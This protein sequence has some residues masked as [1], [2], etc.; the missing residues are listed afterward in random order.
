M[1]YIYRR[2]GSNEY[3]Q[4]MFW[5]KTKKKM[6]TPLNPSFAIKMWFNGVTFHG[7]VFLMQFYVAVGGFLVPHPQNNNNSISQPPRC[8]VYRI[9]DEVYVAETAILPIKFV[10]KYLVYSVYSMTFK[11]GFYCLQK[12]I[13]SLNF[14]LLCCCQ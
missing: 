6:F 11:V 1:M 13:I 4:S 8:Q 12:N 14:F 9:T 2:G 10:I 3:L 5:I 7:H